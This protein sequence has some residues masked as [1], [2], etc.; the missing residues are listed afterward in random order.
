MK[1]QPSVLGWAVSKEYYKFVS[2]HW[3]T[4]FQDQVFHLC[5]LD[6]RSAL[7]DSSQL[8]VLWNQVL[9]WWNPSSREA[10]PFSNLSRKEDGSEGLQGNTGNG[11]RKS[12]QESREEERVGSGGKEVAYCILRKHRCKGFSTMFYASISVASKFDTTKTRAATLPQILY[13]PNFSFHWILD[14]N[15]VSIG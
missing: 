10:Q 12:G 7:C 1:W 6:C 8:T 5:S 2:F 9:N 3:I 11:R 13:W 15:N 14:N 4:V